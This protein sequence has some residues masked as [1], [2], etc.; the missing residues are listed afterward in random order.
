MLQRSRQPGTPLKGLLTLCHSAGNAQVLAPAQKVSAKSVAERGEREGACVDKE[1]LAEHR[2]Q[3]CCQLPSCSWP[4][5]CL[6]LPPAYLIT[7]EQT[8]VEPLNLPLLNKHQLLRTLG[9]FMTFVCGAA[10]CF[11]WFLAQH[12]WQVLWAVSLNWQLWQG[13]KEDVSS[14]SR[15][16]FSGEVAFLVE[17]SVRSRPTLSRPAGFW[18]CWSASLSPSLGS[19]SL[20]AVSLHLP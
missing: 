12:H 4:L 14:S 7:A 16:V 1:Y 13:R 8:G 2:A 6:V 18:Q 19:S 3:L 20:E 15:M 17:L 11:T 9:Q 10:V 5:A